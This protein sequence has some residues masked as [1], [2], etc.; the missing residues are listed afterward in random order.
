M[1]L[2]VMAVSF[3]C[4][5]QPVETEE[6][7]TPVAVATPT[8]DVT[9]DPVVKPEVDVVDDE[10]TQLERLEHIAKSM[11]DVYFDFD[12]SDLRD[13]TRMTLQRHAN[14]LQANSDINVL[15][16]GHCDERGTEEYNMALGERRAERVR[17]YLESLGVSNSRMRTVSY[18][19]MR[20]K[21][22][23]HDEEAWAMNRR[24]HFVLSLSD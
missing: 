17:S 23:R 6:P 16:E 21:D 10:P 12:K 14:V 20:P 5:T 15:I 4:K 11:E 1:L 7:P 3:S 19:E 24:G 8:E 9:S 22:N 18:G 2:A 13:D